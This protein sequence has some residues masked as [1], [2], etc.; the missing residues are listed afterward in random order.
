MV[1]DCPG[2]F[3]NRVLSPYFLAFNQLLVDGVDIRQADKVMT[4]LYGWPMGPAHLLDVV[5][6]DTS[7]HAI[8]VMAEGFPERMPVP[9]NNIVKNFVDAGLL[10]QKSG[11]GFYQWKKGKPVKNAD[12]VKGI[13]LK[14]LGDELMA[15]YFEECRACLEDEITAGVD[16]L[17]A[18]MIFGTGFAPFRGGP[19]FY[20]EKEQSDG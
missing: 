17:D 4:G 8:D 9:G 5:G 10:G 13:N 7:A 12:A 11:E 19:M 16:L 18:G 2:F 1:N 14:T 3:V 6:L 15:P 20:L